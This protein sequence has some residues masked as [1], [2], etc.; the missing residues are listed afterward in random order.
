MY[1]KNVNLFRLQST[2][3]VTKLMVFYSLSTLGIFSA[4]CIFLYPT[5]TRVVSQINGSPVAH[6]TTAECYKKLIVTLLLI[7]VSAIIFG[8]LCARNGLNRMRE[9]EAKMEQITVDS[10]QERI[11]INEW[12]KELQRFGNKF[13]LML[14]RISS[15]YIQLSQFSS[16]IAHELRTPIQ[17][18]RV[19]T[20][21]ELSKELPSE[22]HRTSLEAYMKEYQHLSKLIENLLFLARSDHGQLRLEL[23]VINVNEEIAAVCDYYQAL[24]EERNIYLSCTGQAYLKVDPTLFKRVVSNLLS[25]ALR[26]TPAGGKVVLTIE[27]VNQ[28][29]NIEITDSGTG[30]APEHL[31]RLFDRF[32]RVD[33][34]R[35]THTGGLGLGLAIVKSI[36]D[37]HQGYISCK[38]ELNTGTSILLQLPACL[39]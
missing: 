19:I 4:I 15:S 28:Y 34:S 17:N 25:N 18:L 1:L 24:A 6:I 22:A 13:N 9:F 20:E 26:H 33:S 16:D 12:P 37:L 39:H 8:Y 11:D 2:S 27:T 29:T 30:I 23:E 5:F 35:T 36:I 14:D 3:L 21:L 7:S 10:I 38:S 31:P 32:Y